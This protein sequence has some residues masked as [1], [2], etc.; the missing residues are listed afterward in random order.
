[1]RSLREFASTLGAVIS[2]D[3]ALGLLCLG[4]CFWLFPNVVITIVVV[5]AVVSSAAS[6]IVLAWAVGYLIADR[7]RR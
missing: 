3:I 4:L 7:F 5:M 1:M 2:S 6:L